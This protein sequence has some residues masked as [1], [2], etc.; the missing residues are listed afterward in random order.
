M[1]IF[2][3]KSIRLF[4]KSALTIL[5][6]AAILFN[7]VACAIPDAIPTNSTSS[8]FLTTP[9]ASESI[10]ETTS[11]SSTV[12]SSATHAS[13]SLSTSASSSSATSATE[14]SASE[15]SSEIVTPPEFPQMQIAPVSLNLVQKQPLVD[16]NAESERTILAERLE[17]YQTGLISDNLD[18]LSRYTAGGFT[19][20]YDTNADKY[21]VIDTITVDDT[22]LLEQSYY[23][24]ENGL[25]LDSVYADFY[26]VEIDYTADGK[27]EGLYYYDRYYIYH[28]DADGRLTDIYRDGSLYKSFKYNANGKIVKEISV[29]GQR[30]VEKNYVYLENGALYSVNGTPINKNFYTGNASF[31]YAYTFNGERFLTS[32]T[33]NG[34]TTSYR[35]VGDKIV[36]LSRADKTIFYILDKDLNYIGLSF[37]GEKYYFAVD[38][39]GNVMALVNCDGE[40]VVEYQHDIWGNLLGISGEMANTLGKLNEILNLNGLYDHDLKCYFFAQDIYDPANG[41]TVRDNEALYAKSMYEWTQSQYFSR[42]AV[43]SF[44]R[45]HDMVVEVAVKALKHEG[46]DVT[47]ALYA[48]DQNGDSKRLVDIYT[49][50]Y[51][52][53][54]FSTMNLL[55]GNQIYEV[56]YHAPDSQNFDAIAL[57]KLQKIT[58]KNGGWSVSYFADYHPS[59]GTMKFKGQFI[60]LGYLIEYK[61]KG[62]G[63]IEYQVKHNIEENYDQTINIYDYDAQRYVCYV[64][65]TFD[66]DFLNG[67]TIIPG[68][69]REQYKAI[70][71]YLSEYLQSVAGNICDQ[72]LIYNDPTY[73]DLINMNVMPDYWAQMNLEDT[74]TYLEIQ[75]NGSISVQKMHSWE[76]DA[77]K[78]R[79]LVGSGV[80]LVT[81]VVATVAIAI[82]GANCVVVSICVGA[83]Q[84]A[85]AGAASGFA[86][87]FVSPVMKMA[88]DGVLTGEWKGMSAE[89]FFDQALNEAVKGFESGAITGAILGGISGGLNPKYCFEEGTPIAAENGLVAIES[90]A[91]GDLVWSYDYLTGEKS[92]KPVTATV[93]RETNRMITVEVGGEKIVTTPEHPFYVVDHDLYEGYVAAKYLSVGDRLMTA[94][95]GYLTITSIEQETLDEPITVYNFT[96]DENH[97][98]YV[99]ENSLLVHNTKCSYDT[100][101]S[102]QFR[103]EKTLHS[104][105]EK[106]AKEFGDITMAEYLSK[107]QHLANSPKHLI[108]TLPNGEKVFYNQA[109]N[110]FLKLS[111][112]GFIKTFFR[113]VD[114][115]NY[116]KALGYII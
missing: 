3:K 2:M 20:A 39:Y 42:S 114:G 22:I 38:P 13:S 109:A 46:I 58:N 32:K 36:E 101:N 75:A 28:Y 102:K 70:D 51:E 31:A 112:D 15:S 19:V 76:T 12:A 35:Y 74:I 107:A 91:V 1:V 80:I 108:T 18:G 25:F 10:F 17:G 23:E 41:I 47:S 115:I 88:V 60:Y 79:L 54:P 96:V 14:T 87:G 57:E 85:L 106:H 37:N 93:V 94:D 97:S 89:E 40:F 62:N 61:C 56:I 66:L 55:N 111:S 104:H 68:I 5:L 33:V 53:T 52:I 73:Y 48:N 26:E 86:M 67:V 82:P 110:E 59:A 116:L 8:I 9:S 16:K 98:Y 65:N 45:I 69:N 95:G 81:A 49:L 11:A 6:T 24:L 63:I 105:Y 77:F 44:A 27:V 7:L 92:L 71:G 78:T 50:P 21:G 34:I 90:I 64:N 99:G 72:M 83:A 100:L 103:N 84:G 113:P 29:T 30:S 4:A 43:S